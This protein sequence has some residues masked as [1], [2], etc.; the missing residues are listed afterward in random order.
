[1]K[2]GNKRS[3]I[4]IKG[5]AILLTDHCEKVR[6]PHCYTYLRQIEAVYLQCVGL[7]SAQQEKHT[8]DIPVHNMEENLTAGQLLH[9]IG[10]EKTTNNSMQ[11]PAHIQL[12]SKNCSRV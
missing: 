8:A 4:E 5:K 1:M 12:N 6:I 2:Y 10:T 7:E 9:S 11:R 3:R